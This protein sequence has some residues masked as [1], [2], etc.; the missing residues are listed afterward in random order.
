MGY[1]R[2]YGNYVLLERLGAGG[3][4]EIDLAR[5]VVEEAS[6]MRFL[7]IK[8]I[9]GDRLDDEAFVRMFKDEARISA[10]LHHTNIA[11]VYDFG[12]I[13]EEYYLVLEYVPG[14]DIRRI[15]NVMRDRGEVIPLRIT[16]RLICDLLAGLHYAHTRTDTF[17]KPMQIVHRDVNPRNIMV[18]IR[19][20]V[21]LIDFG[22]A[23]ATDRLERTQTDHVKGKFAYMAPEQVSGK[24]I[25]GR[26]D[27]FAAALTLHEMI[28]GVG[29]FYGLN[30]VQI[31]HRLLNGQVPELPAH[32]DLA[33]PAPLRRVQRHALATRPEDRYADADAYR[34][35]LERIAERVG[36]LASQR[37]LA[38]FVKSIEPDFEEL[39]RAKMA[40]YSGPIETLQTTMELPAVQVHASEVSGSLS[41]LHANSQVT[42]TNIAA[43][44]AGVAAVG[45][46][47]A[48][49]IGAIALVL[50]VAIAATGLY[51]REDLSGLIG[52]A[53][54][55]PPGADDGPGIHDVRTPDNAVPV[56]PTRAED[57]APTAPVEPETT[58]STQVP[59]GH[60]PG[61]AIRPGGK[62]PTD[63]DAKPDAAV[64][65]GD[66][67]PG[68]PDATSAPGTGAADATPPI[69]TP[70]AV[71]PVTTA[72]TT[73]VATAPA[74]AEAAGTLQVNSTEKGRAI[75]ING[76]KT[77]YLTPAKFA[78]P[79]GTVIVSVEGYT[80]K[81]IELRASN[82]A[83]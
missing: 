68:T 43:R 49:A 76:V 39:L 57:G 25:D 18:S 44:S 72:A 17:G 37:D 69:T 6:F 59:A 15:I 31:M 35:D 53:G 3:M 10:E 33:D 61:A 66:A 11:Q 34:R 14:I 20:D 60:V 56:E 71:P 63:A 1:P 22:V 77:P 51:F 32:P 9:K 27:V 54:A 73:A 48:A 58:G 40:N 50:L 80:A 29:P 28:E 46:L 38:E 62:D 82:S 78:W 30:Q 45:G 42:Y 19:G 67:A 5:R 65:P 2:N 16:L 4:S 8:R 47:A 74:A 13:D 55:H 81:T 12:K 23:K 41:K 79:S 7:V 52:T 70:V 83:R 75:Y 64:R 26:V 21:K 36:G 24:E